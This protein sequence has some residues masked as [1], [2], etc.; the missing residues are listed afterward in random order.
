ARPIGSDD[1][2]PPSLG[3][4]HA[5][6]GHDRPLAELDREG[7]Y[8]EGGHHAGSLV[9]LHAAL[10]FRRSTAMKNGAPMNAVMTPIGI[11]AGATTVRARLSTKIRND[12]PNS[13]DRGSTGR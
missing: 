7:A 11:S 12:A 6:V 3:D 10:R 9:E 4:V 13:A 5:D 1:A 8:F 2:Y